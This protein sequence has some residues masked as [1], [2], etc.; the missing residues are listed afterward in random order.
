MKVSSDT[1][2]SRWLRLIAILAAVLQAACGSGSSSSS[3]SAGS[4][5]SSLR[6]ELEGNGVLLAERRAAAM[7]C[8]R[9]CRH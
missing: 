1:L 3:S 7:S 5:S 9:S 8:P 4:S 6:C 2:R